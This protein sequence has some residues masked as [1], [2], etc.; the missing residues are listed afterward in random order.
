VNSGAVA[1]LWT[2]AR[3]ARRP[4]LTLTAGGSRHARWTYP[5]SEI[6]M[7]TLY[8]VILGIVV[9]VAF[10]GALIVSARRS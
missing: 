3:A 7:A 1:A 2:C 4:D 6:S 9:M 8:G 5:V 10:I